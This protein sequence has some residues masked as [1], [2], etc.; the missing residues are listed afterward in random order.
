VETLL[1]GLMMRPEQA[2]KAEGR[3]RK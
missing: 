1:H 3:V 2:A